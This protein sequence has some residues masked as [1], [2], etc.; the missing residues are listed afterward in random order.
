MLQLVVKDLS[1]GKNV[2]VAVLLTE[3]GV[4]FGASAAGGDI[5]EVRVEPVAARVRLLL[6]NDFDL[7]AHLQLIGKRHDAAANFGAD[8][9]MTDVAMDMVGKIERRR[10]RRQVHHVAFRRKDI[11]PVVKDLAAHFVEHFAG[12]GHLFLPGNQLA[13]PGD[14]VLIAA[15]AAGPRSRALFVLPMRGHAQLGV[16][17]HLPGADLNLHGLAA[18][19]QH[20]GM[21]RLVAVGFR[22]GHVV[23]ELIR[24]VT[25]VGMNDPQRGITILQPLGHDAHRA[26]VKQLVKG[27]VFFLHFA[28]D[29]VDMLRPTIDLGLDP[30]GFHFCPQVA[31]ELVDIMLAVDTAFVEQF[32]NALVLCRMQVAEAVIFQLPLQLADT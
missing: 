25:V 20:H 27:E 13:Q 19:P 2:L 4:N 9:A 22:V 3:P 14:T 26:Y 8:A 12:V 28:P 18:R 5:A 32:G 11:H 21:D 23:I 1:A 15:A 31:D 7:I 24:Q 29:A 6:G 17:M 10:P 16:F 30:F